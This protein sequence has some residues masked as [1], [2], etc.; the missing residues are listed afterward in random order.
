MFII[1]KL[2]SQLF[3]PV[4]LCLEIFIVGV[5]LLLFTRKQRSGK[6]I[7][8]TGVVL[9]ISMSYTTLPNMLL[10]P[11]EY[12]YPPIGIANPA[13]DNHLPP[14]K[15]IVALGGGHTSDPKIPITSQVSGASLVRLIEAIRLYKKIPGSKL[16]LSGGKVF[17]TTPEAEIMAEIARTIGVHDEDLI[18]ESDSKDTSDQARLIQPIIGDDL[19]LLVTSAAHMPRSIALFKSLGMH[20]IAAPT[21]YLTKES[22]SLNADT[23]FPG[24]EGLSKTEC[25]LHEY[26]GCIWSKLR[27]QNKY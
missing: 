3:Y 11:L 24:T 26:L 18:L 7:I 2:I 4:P 1:K 9:L 19:F 21:G 16:I 8:L 22:Q 5:V 6:L 20:P 12:R 25:A 17:D 13:I 10:K 14:A 15:W 23:I 27:G